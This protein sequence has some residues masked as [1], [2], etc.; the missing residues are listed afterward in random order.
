LQIVDRAA[1]DLGVE[2]KPSPLMLSSRRVA[3]RSL[4][5]KNATAELA[6]S[7]Q[8]TL[9]RKATHLKETPRPAVGNPKV[10]VAGKES[11]ESHVMCE[12]RSVM[13]Y[14]SGLHFAIRRD[15]K[16][17]GPDVSQA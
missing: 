3:R 16:E 6:S 11:V 8:A 9:S 2:S 14:P 10:A 13:V 15:R 1:Q 7:T 17:A 5:L 4:A 12:F